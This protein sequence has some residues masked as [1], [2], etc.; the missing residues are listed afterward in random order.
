MRAAA[1]PLTIRAALRFAPW[2]VPLPLEPYVRVHF[3]KVGGQVRLGLHTYLDLG[4][5]AGLDTAALAELTL[6]LPAATSALR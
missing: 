4:A 2:V 1:W 3:T 5:K 6:A